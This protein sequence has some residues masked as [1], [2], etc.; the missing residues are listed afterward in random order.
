MTPNTAISE[1][2]GPPPKKQKRRSPRVHYSEN[3]GT[4]DDDVAP[5]E[6]R[7]SDGIA[8]RQS[9]SDQPGSLPQENSW[10]RHQIEHG[11]PNP[12]RFF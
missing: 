4:D 1:D 8:K 9:K 7:L 5:V 3:D 6:R 11:R 12:K 2:D 10:L